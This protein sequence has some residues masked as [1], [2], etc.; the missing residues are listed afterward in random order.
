MMI[1]LTKLIL[2]LTFILSFIPPLHSDEGD[3][4]W[5][6]TITPTSSILGNGGSGITLLGNQVF[7]SGI[8]D[9]NWTTTPPQLNG[10]IAG[11]DISTGREVLLRRIQN[12]LILDISSLETLNRLVISGAIEGGFFPIPMLY[13]A[14]VN[15]ANGNIV[16][17][18]THNTVSYAGRHIPFSENQIYVSANIVQNSD[19]GF[20]L[21][22]NQAQLQ[23]QQISQTSTQEYL[24][25]IKVST[26]QYIYAIG[27][28]RADN[29][30][31]YDIMVI[32]WAPQLIQPQ[33]LIINYNNSNDIGGAIYITKKNEI[34]VAGYVTLSTE[35]FKVGLLITKLNED[36]TYSWD[37][38]FIKELTTDTTG[39]N[40]F[41]ANNFLPLCDITQDETT[42]NIYVVYNEVKNEIP[43]ANLIKIDKNKNILLERTYPYCIFTSLVLDGQKN[44]YV[45]GTSFETT[46]EIATWKL[47]GPSSALQAK[48][49]LTG[50]VVSEEEST[51]LV[52]AIIE[53]FKGTT[54]VAQTAAG[55]DG[56]YHL[57]ISTGVY[58]VKASSYGYVSEF[59][60]QVY[61]EENSTTTVNFSLEKVNFGFL[62]GTV[63]SEE[64]QP[65]SNATI[66]ALQNQIIISSTTTQQDGSYHMTLDAGSYDIEVSKFGYQTQVATSVVITPLGTTIKNFILK[67]S[68]VGYLE[69]KILDQQAQPLQGA[70]VEIFYNSVLLSSTTADINGSYFISIPAG[71][72]EV[73]AS[74]SGFVSKSSTV[75]II[76]NSTI[77]LNFVLQRIPK[78]IVRGYVLN[79]NG[80]PIN[81]AT[82]SFY[83]NNELIT[84][85]NSNNFGFYEVTVPTGSYKVEIYAVNYQSKTEEGIIVYESSVTYK[86]FILTRIPKGYIT[87]T[88]T[89]RPGN[90]PVVGAV[91]KVLLDSQVVIST[92]ARVDGSYFL[93]VASGVYNIEVSSG[94]YMTVYSTGIIVNDN[95]TVTLNFV[96]ERIRTGVIEGIV[97][98]NETAQ[99]LK[100]ATVTLK[101]YNVTVASTTTDENG[102]Y[103]F[104]CQIGTYIV[105]ASLAGFKTQQKTA[106]VLENSTTTL[107]FL[108]SAAYYIEGKV[109]T[110]FN[111]PLE[112]TT[113]ILVC[114]TD[115]T[116]LQTK[117]NTEGIYRFSELIKADY[118]VYPQ[119]EGWIFEPQQYIYT[120]LSSNKTAQNFTAYQQQLPPEQK[121]TLPIGEVSA[122]KK[123]EIK[124]VTS[125]SSG[126]ITSEDKIYILFNSVPSKEYTLK[127]ITLLGDKVYET[128]KTATDAYEFFE[129]SLRLKDLSSGTYLLIIESEN[130]KLT[131]KISLVR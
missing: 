41:L 86:N 1:K 52:G 106:Q 28:Q 64:S 125:N 36:L 25:D 102:S 60:P 17:S 55:V 9:T 65:I 120:Q 78:G 77:T 51:P 99:P 12:T 29:N 85:T 124:V 39:F 105:E 40:Y 69:G 94:G 22:N 82:L 115:G 56:K 117:T 75:V 104:I 121:I 111:Q 103:K 74:S 54:L 62:T 68:P 66:L 114:L 98:N 79:T 7:I 2:F 92:T 101:I 59:S 27:K 8:I 95:E 97:L 81:M 24:Y 119:K 100:D 26:N 19:S 5:K 49:Y 129:Y 13:F 45:T 34:Y 122:P 31:D 53:V 46:I 80:E 91:I 118:K 113:V 63:L 38:P 50:S 131:K 126:K 61:I 67:K 110:S 33:P 18:Y 76:E 89:T 107:N 70:V 14:V 87:G 23:Q 112:D 20:F 15:P 21:F 90:R 48:G 108:L 35:P 57:E 16:E 96:L 6:S 10:V 47:E 116:T 123:D 83:L 72:Y 43:Y 130:S 58:I 73:K 128:K 93:E 32:R 30:D 84:T 71:T 11:Y 109:V 3:I 4:I 88:I 44:I 37:K 42:E 127:I